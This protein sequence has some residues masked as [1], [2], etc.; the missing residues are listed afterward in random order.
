MGQL[1]RQSANAGSVTGESYAA[2]RI[3]AGL[4]EWLRG[5]GDR[6]TQEERNAFYTAERW[7]EAGLTLG[8]IVSLLA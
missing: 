1:S 7:L 5:D 6:A 8:G 4:F 2:A 3:R